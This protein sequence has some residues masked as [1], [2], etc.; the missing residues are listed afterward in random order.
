MTMMDKIT[1]QEFYQEHKKSIFAIVN[2]RLPDLEDAKDVVQEIFM[3]LWLKKD[4]LHTIRDMQPYLYVIARNHVISAFRKKNIQLKNEGILLE[5]LNKFDYSAE[6]N[7][8]ARELHEQIRGIVEHL[9]DTTRQCYHLSK[10]E[11]KKNGEIANLLNISEKTVRN[12]ISEALK[13]LRI[14]L[15]ENHPEIFALFLFLLT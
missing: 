8:I 7:T 2:L 3:E 11:G 5:G 12:N 1:F 13:R 6:E 14:L 10:N 9:P 4:S 15:K